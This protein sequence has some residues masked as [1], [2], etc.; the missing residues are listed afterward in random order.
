MASTVPASG[1]DRPRPGSGDDATIS[2]TP[3]RDAEGSVAA[4]APRRSE[5][6]PA[7]SPSP[8]RAP[9]ATTAGGTATPVGRTDTAGPPLAGAGRRPEVPPPPPPRSG[10]TP[11]VRTT[12]TSG[13][14]AIPSATGPAGQPAPDTASTDA[15]SARHRR[16]PD[17]D[18]V[19]PLRYRILP[20]TAIGI[21]MAILF[22]AFGASL[23]GVV[24]YSYYEYRLNQNEDKV[25]ALT[26]SLPNQAKQAQA[27]LK[28]Q[29]AA[30]S[31]EINSQLT[32]LKSLL[33]SGQ[34]MQN[35][36]AKAAPAMYFVHTLDQAGQPSVGSAFAVATDSRQ[37]LLLTSYTVVQAATRQPGPQVFV[38]HGGNDQAVP[39]YTWDESKD[40]A[41]LILPA[42]NQP[43]MSFVTA[44]PQTGERVFALSG[45]GAQGA[46]IT[47]G[48]VA[49]VSANG[50]QHDATTGTQFQGGPLLNSDG[51][52]VGIL[53]RTYAPLG[54]AVTDVWF[55][56]PPSS[57]CQRVLSCTNGA[58]SGAGPG[59]PG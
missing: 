16:L 26:S 23:S 27:A 37:T 31:A 22:F 4:D 50:I 11:V 52:V 14:T 53:S 38:R 39:V 17:A 35:L 45:L 30:A 25:S 5:A 7:S 40:L 48:F 41:L 12:P 2:E 19:R 51:L 1:G 21:S 42:P 29:E 32:P 10:S 58:L 59:A 44:P 43:T 13:Q 18:A 6:A 57:A 24:L 47:Q 49:D 55:A 15:R 34:T 54:F 8:G 28:A 20:R 56:V 33:A 9:G 3:D 36:A 46:S